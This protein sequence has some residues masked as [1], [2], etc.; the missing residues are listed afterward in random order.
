MGNF[1]KFGYDIRVN[2]DE[3]SSPLPPR[4]TQLPAE[5]EKEVEGVI[6]PPPLSNV[7]SPPP[8]PPKKGLPRIVGVVAA[9]LVLAAVGWIAMTIIV[10]K[11]K[12]SNKGGVTINYWGLWED[13]NVMEGILS[14]FEAKNP[15]I[16]VNYK[17]N[18]KD[19]YR[20]RLQ[21]RLLKNSEEEEV[22]DIF[23][24]HVG[25]IPMFRDSL[26]VMPGTTV[27][28][29]Q[30]E[31]DFFDV[32]K[33]E[34]KEGGNYLAIPLMYDG[35]AMFYNRDLI[36]S[37]QVEVPKSWWELQNVVERLTV[38]D[39]LGKIKIAGA[40]L[41][42]ADNVD[43]WSDIVGLIIRQDGGEIINDDGENN[44]RIRDVL[45]YYTNFRTKYHVWDESLPSS[46][47]AFAAGKLA[48]YFGPSWRVFNIEEMNPG[49][50]FEVTAMPQLPT[51]KGVSSEEANAPANLTDIHWASY[52]VEG[53][54]N[55]SKHLK[56]SWALL[57]YLASSETMEKLY[58]AESE[59]RSFGEI[60]PRKSLRGKMESNIKIKPFV[61][62]A[63]RASGWYLYSRTFDNGTNDEMIKYFGD[64]VN[65]MALQNAD[66][67]KTVETL[68]NGINQLVAKY[69]IKR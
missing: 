11:F 14:D 15:N 36:D 27:K 51:L 2:I 40:A 62:V 53:V 25:W 60:L 69:K 3:I 46:T 21:A 67:D 65:A 5:E 48:F 57:E 58:K 64:A 22:P 8:E 16:K 47:E 41:G 63:D 68:R 4:P 44:R 37:A 49:L 66:A 13:S 18:Q 52:W 32:Y 12:E 29:L 23:R 35:L 55:K 24:I 17:K 56:E 10:A 38:R 45:V 33:N 39:D 59:V 6:P 9:L 19:N 50:R 30:L 42:L 26:A 34:L 31:E 54:N 28:K 43:H 61:S 1:T 7:A 20:S